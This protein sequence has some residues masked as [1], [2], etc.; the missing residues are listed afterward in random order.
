[1]T[2]GGS[3]KPSIDI[4]KLGC[5]SGLVTTNEDDNPRGYGGP[6]ARTGRTRWDHHPA[7]RGDPAVGLEDLRGVRHHHAHAVARAAAKS[8]QRA[9]ESMG[10]F[11]LFD[12]RVDA[13]AEDEGSVGAELGNAPLGERRG[14]PSAVAAAA[15][16][17]GRLDGHGRG[18]RR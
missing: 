8:D 7:R 1:M 3:S 15:G 16:L 13:V 17:G 4:D 14:I 5:S 12:V 9:G 18:G 2:T 6:R 11:E 10:R